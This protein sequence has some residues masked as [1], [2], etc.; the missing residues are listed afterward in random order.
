[1]SPNIEG[2]PA[3]GGIIRPVVLAQERPDWPEA[4]YHITHKSRQG[5]TLEAPSDFP[6]AV[7]VNALVTA[8]TLAIN[9]LANV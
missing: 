9:S 2:R 4:L 1:L 6:L 5:Y 8:V 3:F 7:R